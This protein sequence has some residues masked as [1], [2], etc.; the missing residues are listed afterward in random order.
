MHPVKLIHQPVPSS[1]LRKWSTKP[2]DSK[3]A[4][5]RSNQRHHRERV[6]CHIADLEAR[7]AETQVQLEKALAHVTD[8]SNELLHAKTHPTHLS[9]SMQVDGQ[10]TSNDVVV[11]RRSA[12]EP[13]LDMS[14]C[15]SCA[16]QES[17]SITGNRNSPPSVSQENGVTFLQTRL[18]AEESL[19]QEHSA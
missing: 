15:G 8:L 12:A 2:A 14:C 17:D 13:S 16:V 1:M 19:S 7:L 6:R 11:T 10:G 9:V 3:A 5:L 18:F 4:R